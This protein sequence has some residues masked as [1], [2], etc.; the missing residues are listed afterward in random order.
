MMYISRN[1]LKKGMVGWTWR[2][3]D[4]VGGLDDE[5]D[6]GPVV[7]GA[8]VGGGGLE[9]GRQGERGAAARL[10]GCSSAGADVRLK[11]RRERKGI[12]GSTGSRLTGGARGQ[13]RGLEEDRARWTGRA[14]SARTRG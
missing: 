9:P 12:R 1:H 11:G 3:A 8:A 10:K 4:G 2:A 14:T 5:A 13:A 6:G 7:E